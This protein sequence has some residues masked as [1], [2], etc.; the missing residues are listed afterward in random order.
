MTATGAGTGSITPPAGV[1]FASQGNYCPF[2][3]Q[4]NTSGYRDHH[5]LSKSGNGVGG[6]T[7]LR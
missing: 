7:I 1:I 3:V 6:F 2:W 4:V 5:R